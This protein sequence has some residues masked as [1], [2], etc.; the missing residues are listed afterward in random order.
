M[1]K[2]YIFHLSFIKRFGIY[3]PFK[4]YSKLRVNIK[5][6]AL[7][8][9]K[10]RVV[11][12]DKKTPEISTSATSFIFQNNS[13]IEFGQRVVFGGGV[14]LLVKPKAFLSIGD[15]TY[16]TSDTHIES[17]N[18]IKIGNDCA[19][20]WGVTIIDDDHHTI[21]YDS[22]LKNKTTGSV[23]I[24]NK[25]WIGCN[26]TILKNTI[27]GNNCVIAAGSVVKGQFPDNVL[28][29]GNPARII[30]ENVSWE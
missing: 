5:T 25:V 11:V 13:T 17:V 4:V 8:N 3:I 29:G 2:F 27:I 22:K 21:K 30:K 18:T 10:S 20:S 24:G 16:I 6:S 12:G 7:V 19:I 28:I 1:L 26:V 9:F 23:L 14:L 15:N